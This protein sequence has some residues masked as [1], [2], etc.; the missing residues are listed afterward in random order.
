MKTI[1]QGIKILPLLML[2]LSVNT[3]SDVKVKPDEKVDNYHHL[4]CWQ[5]GKLLFEEIGLDGNFYQS[6]SP[7]EGAS[8]KKIK[9][10]SSVIQLMKIGTSTCLY[11]KELATK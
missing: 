4:R 2:I 9:D 7:L 8:F 6:A 10:K 1:N 5:N 11:K 3:F